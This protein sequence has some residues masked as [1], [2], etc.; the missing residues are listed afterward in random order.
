MRKIRYERVAILIILVLSIVF[1]IHKSIS[2]MVKIEEFKPVPKNDEVSMEYVPSETRLV[3]VVKNIYDGVEIVFDL[4]QSINL[5]L[6]S[7]DDVYIKVCNKS[8]GEGII[9][10]NKIWD[11][12]ILN[13]DNYKFKNGIIKPG[14][15]K[16]VFTESELRN[17]DSNNIYIDF[18]IRKNG[19]DI[20]NRQI[21]NL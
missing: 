14:T 12:Y 19:E 17:V 13:K 20:Y 21:S 8:N 15:Y 7:P 16:V 6:S 9:E 4:C 2:K 18:L 5:E 3:D 10:K 11:K 1:F